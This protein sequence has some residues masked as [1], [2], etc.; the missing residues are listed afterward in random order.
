MQG[1]YLPAIACS[2]NF[3]TSQG[4]T[5][6]A[7]FVEKYFSLKKEKQTSI[8]DESYAIAD[9]NSSTSNRKRICGRR[10]HPSEYSFKASQNMGCSRKSS[11]SSVGNAKSVSAPAAA[12][13]GFSEQRFSDTHSWHENCSGG[14]GVSMNRSLCVYLG[15]SACSSSVATMMRLSL[16]CVNGSP[17]STT[18]PAMARTISRDRVAL[19]SSSNSSRREPCR[20]TSSRSS[21]PSKPCSFWNSSTRKPSPHDASQNSLKRTHATGLHS[22]DW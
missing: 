15:S 19:R 5:C 14:G 17:A 22:T 13:S 21:R 4:D 6:T 20:N 10:P 1:E 11:S 2:F 18:R 7:R 8:K 16:P 3:S 9:R 12:P